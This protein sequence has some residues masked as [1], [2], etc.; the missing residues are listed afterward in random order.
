MILKLLRKFQLCPCKSKGEWVAGKRNYDRADAGHG[1]EGRRKNRNKI[2][3]ERYIKNKREERE[4]ERK[5]TRVESILCLT[6]EYE[7]SSYSPIKVKEN[8]L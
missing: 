4:K 1:K 5:K 3:I 8:G 7:S 6:V 2:S